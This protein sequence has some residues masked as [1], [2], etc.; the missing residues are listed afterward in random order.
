MENSPRTFMAFLILMLFLGMASA[1]TFIYLLIIPHY[2]PIINCSQF[3]SYKEAVQA[4]N[5]GEWKL[6]K[7]HNGVP[8]ENLL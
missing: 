6:D 1:V 2:R 3:S 8:C 4:Y 7:N 5:M